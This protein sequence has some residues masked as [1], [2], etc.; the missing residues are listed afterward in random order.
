MC[1]TQ[2]AESARI[3]LQL[4]VAVVGF[5]HLHEENGMLSSLVLF[6]I[7]LLLIAELCE[8]GVRGRAFAAS[9]DGGESR[10]IAVSAL[11]SSLRASSSAAPRSVT[12]DRSTTN[13]IN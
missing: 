9:P 5:S 10:S 4:V 2:R 1:L 3:Q 11:F 13:G 8:L 7:S 12:T 6:S